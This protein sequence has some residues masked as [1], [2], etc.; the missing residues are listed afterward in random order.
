MN[1]CVAGID[2]APRPHYVSFL[3]RAFRR[4]GCTVTV[5]G[6]PAGS[7]SGPNGYVD[8]AFEVPAARLPSGAAAG[9]YDLTV[10]VDQGANWAVVNQGTSYAY[11]WRESNPN[12]EGR[13]HGAARGAP[14]FRC[15]LGN[16]KAPWHD[17]ETYLP[18]AVDREVFSGGRPWAEREHRLVYTGRE[19]GNG[20]FDR[21]RRGLDA[22]CVDYLDGYAA[23][24][25]LLGNSR[26]TYVVDSGRYVGSRGLEA[27]AQGCVVHWDG[28][29]ALERAGIVNNK[30]WWPAQRLR[31]D[32]CRATGEYI[33]AAGF[34]QDVL[35]LD[36]RLEIGD[37]GE[38]A[39]R[40]SRAIILEAHT[41][42]HRAWTI[43][44]AC[45][46]ELPRRLNEAGEIE[47]GTA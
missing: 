31:T 33:P 46:V 42:E 18:F 13:V 24:A 47:G 41:D 25:E 39:S 1:V 14:V 32:L 44:R 9:A 38:D 4:L 19:R 8:P 6:G 10:M 11:V 36:G 20:T 28:G 17:G 3:A 2:Y 16:G 27:M 35:E 22:R 15:M 29:E 21:L 34:E 43:A 26:H 7:D 37:A 5:V 12:E 40:K 30:I 45:G 23:Y